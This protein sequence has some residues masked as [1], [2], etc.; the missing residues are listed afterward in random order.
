MVSELG[1]LHSVALL[2]FADEI[3]R[4]LRAT[5]LRLNDA[6]HVR[7]DFI[8]VTMAL[9]NRRLTAIELADLAPCGTVV[10]KEGG[11]QT[12]THRTSHMCAADFRHVYNHGVLA[13]W[14][15]LR[16]GSL[17]AATHMPR[18]FDH[19]ELETE[20]DTQEWDLLLARPAH[21]QN[22]ALC[23]TLS[24][25]TGHNDTTRRA[26]M[27]PCLVVPDG[28]LVLGMRFKVTRLDPLEHKLAL[29][30]HRSMLQRLHDRHV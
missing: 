12:E 17:L 6:G 30:L 2:V 7:I 5:A 28:I 23:A 8:A 22:H 20:A 4:R 27:L 14:V 9:P 15:Q 29:A 1:H 11:T 26:Q 18:E 19:G 24:K 21:G 25:A 3:E 16:R 10:G 13:L